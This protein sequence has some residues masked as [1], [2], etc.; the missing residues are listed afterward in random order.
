MS[1][2]RPGANVPDS[3]IAANLSWGG[4]VL[5]DPAFTFWGAAPIED[6]EGRT[7]LFAARWPEENVD[8]AWRESSEIAHYVADDPEGPFDFQ[9]VV[10]SG[11]GRAGDW[12]AYAPH[13]PEIK[14]FGDAYALLFI[15][16]GD[17]HRPPHPL[18]QYTG[19]VVSTSLDGP[20]R[21]VGESGLILKSSPDPGHWTYGKQI[22]NPAIINLNGRYL[23]YFKSQT[24]S[25]DGSVF[26]VAMADS[27]E[28]PYR[29]PDEP[30]TGK[31]ITVE[32]ACVFI[33]DDRVYLLTTD[34]HGQVTGIPG[35]GALWVSDDGVHFDDENA[36]LGYD[37]L[38]AY[39]TD[40]DPA[41]GKHIYGPR[42]KLERPKILMREGKPAYIYGPSGW[43]IH[44]GD[45][46][47]CY[48]LKINL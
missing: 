21:K 25:G 37:L 32:D 29:L 45:R 3:A 1:H 31:D 46:T 44:G 19:M 5:S 12:D 48:V 30:F 4:V 43:A 38:S 8:P 2:N 6:D 20:W 27:L 13:N 17:Y 14:R 16:N 15:A 35:G 42:P 33:W 23:L 36:L 26:G 11:T 9:E 7:H 28:G 39:Y 34:N 40:Y 24:K 41:V 18:N 47:A 22:V 10:L